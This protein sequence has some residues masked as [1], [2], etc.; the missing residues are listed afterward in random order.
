MISNL[1][2]FCEKSVEIRV[3]VNFSP[4]SYEK[5]FREEFLSSG[6]NRNNNITIVSGTTPVLPIDVV[7]ND[8]V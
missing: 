4:N 1:I 6:Y 8:F 3:S 2:L 5:K 7:I